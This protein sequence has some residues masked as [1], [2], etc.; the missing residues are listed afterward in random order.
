MKCAPRPLTLL[1]TLSFLLAG[2]LN[3]ATGPRASGESSTTHVGSPRPAARDVAANDTAVLTY[4]YDNLRT[5][6][7]TNETILTPGNVN[8]SQF[9]KRMTYP[10]DGQVYAQPLYVPNLSINGQPRDV[11][12]VA[13]EHDSVYAFDAD[14]RDPVAGQLWHTNFLANG[15]STVTSGA[16]SCNDTTPEMGITGTPVI[17]PTTNTLYVVAFTNENGQLV[18]R[19]HALD[20][21]SGRDKASLTI[22]ASVAGY[23]QGN[24]DG[25]IAFDARH[26]RQRSALLLVHGNVYIA[27]GSFCDNNPYH[28]WLM[29]YSFEGTTLRQVNVFNDTPDASEGGLWGSGGAISADASGDI[30]YISGNGSFN[31][32][33][34]GRSSGDSVVMLSAD[35]RLLDYFTPFNQGCLARI[36]ADLGSSGPLVEP[37]HNVIIAAGKEG[38]IYV[39]DRLRMGHYRAIAGACSHQ[40]LTNVD[41]VLQESPPGQIGGLYNTPSY[42]NGYVYLASVNKATGAYKLTGAGTFRSFTPDSSTPEAFGFTGGNLVISSNGTSAGILWTLDRGD[43]N[44]PVLRAYDATNLSHELYNSNQNPDRDALG[45]FVKFTCP[46]VANGEVFVPTSNS[47]EIYGQV[48]GSA[49]P[50]PASYN[51]AGMS[52][53]SFNGHNMANYDGGG[54]SYSSGALQDAGIT[55]GASII[56][57]GVTF[58]W[59][60]LPGGTLDNYK[61]NGQ[62]VLVASVDNANTLAFLGSSTGGNASGPATIHYTDGST[63][64][65]TLGLTDWTSATVAFGNQ[66]VATMAYRNGPARKQ[67]LKV[68]LFSTQV[69]LQASKTLKSVTL[70]VA[71]GGQNQLHIFAFAVVG[72]LGSYNN[73]GT[74][75]DSDSREANFDGVGD[76]YSAQALQAQGCNPGDNAF[77]EGT[78]GTVFQW[79]AGDS[80]ELNNY[81]ADGQTLPVEPLDN[82]GTL[83]FAG[84]SVHGPASGTATIN[85]SDGSHQTFLLGFSDWTLN[86]GQAR[87]A[88]AN[89][90]MY[91]MPYHNTLS[92]RAQVKTYVFFASVA[93]QQGKTVRSVTLP[94]PVGGGQMHIFAVATRSAT[95]ENAEGGVR[96]EDG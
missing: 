2:F 6:A 61:A 90:A 93:L 15:S 64:S 35:L 65:F 54:Y 25:R 19:L 14:S 81:I 96:E 30:Y 39:I 53:D 91:T 18:Y 43:A 49:P 24:V 8:V 26:E 36:D 47:L 57:H 56:S 41:A 60:N 67:A 37:A 94:V 52:D 1:F 69:A 55:P 88:F 21:T 74:S 70:P 77:F 51:N 40:K 73:I 11:V 44:G 23:G 31:L 68:S 59:P 28:G 13:T 16:V 50:P 76:S 58:I 84:A 62:T 17:D 46:T 7:T 92:A 79:P 32:N 42:W 9:G 22:Q 10:V 75:D 89:R 27:W 38:R 4:K 63:Q 80:G 83:A 66:V 20:I 86:D 72:P 95:P 12:F 34:G 82:A 78:N 29:S 3:L 71:T 33:T 87:P 45:G 48:N 85:Y 5:G